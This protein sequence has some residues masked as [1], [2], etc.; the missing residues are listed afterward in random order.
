MLVLVVE[1]IGLTAVLP[2]GLL[3][4]FHTLGSG[5]KGLPIDDGRVIL[6]PEKRFRV[7][8]L[9]PCYKVSSLTGWLSG[10]IGRRK[11]LTIKHTNT[12]VA[13]SFCVF[14]DPH[15]QP[16]FTAGGLVYI[17]SASMS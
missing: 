7:H 5:S 11:V 16:P 12:R 15:G 1:L 3:L 8:I 4:P 17:L 14:N 6:P 13:C 2:Y 9:V 10:L